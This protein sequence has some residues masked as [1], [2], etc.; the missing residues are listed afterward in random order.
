MYLARSSKITCNL[1]LLTCA[2]AP[3]LC[4]QHMQHMDACI[5]VRQRSGHPHLILMKF[6]YIRFSSND[7]SGRWLGGGQPSHLPDAHEVLLNDIPKYGVLVY[8][9]LL[10]FVLG[11]MDTQTP[12]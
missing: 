1:G 12:L 7:S 9:T 5:H 11:F 6:I 4:L 3:R 2:K 8:E 10:Y